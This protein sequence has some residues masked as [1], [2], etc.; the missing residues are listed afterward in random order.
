MNVEYSEGIC[1]DGVAILK[2]GVPM[3]VTEIL[4][5]LRKQKTEMNKTRNRIE[6]GDT[7]QVTFNSCSPRPVWLNVKVAYIPCATGDSWIF[8]DENTGAVHYVSEGCTISK[9]P[10]AN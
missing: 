9:A 2:D 6:I 3:S 8:E 1:A 10:N 7:V 4:E 5:E